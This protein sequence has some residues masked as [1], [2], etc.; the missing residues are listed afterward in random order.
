MADVSCRSCASTLGEV[1][2][3]LGEQPACDQFPA[4][5]D[6]GPDPRHPLRMWL[7]AKCGLA[8]LTE[9]PTNP[10]EPRGREPDALVAQARDAVARIAADGLLPAGATVA[11]YGS[12][13]GGSWLDLITERGAVVAPVGAPADVII[14]CFGLMHEPDQR[15]ALA[16]RAARLRPGG[17]LLIQF[18]SL[19]TILRAGQWNAL[20]HGHFA[21][22]ST[23]VLLDM[24]RS[25]GVTARTAHVF[26]LYGGTVLLAASKGG[27]GD[28]ALEALVAAELAEGVR[29]PERVSGMQDAAAVAATWLA[30]E[31]R[32]RR[33]QGQRVLGYSAASRA[34]SLLTLAGLDRTALP[35]I[36]DASPAK[37]GR[38]MP[39]TDIPIIGLDELVAGAP[40][41]VVLFVPDLLPEVRRELPQV[42]AGGG[43]WLLAEQGEGL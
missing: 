16:E 24:L 37:R 25:V 19:A 31:V 34:V 41:A 23:P 33:E 10:A 27:T 43:T 29:R 38:R 20:R 40:H 1:V 4:A 7:C 2:L 18:H 26:P 22:Y 11:E 32:R 12:P 21:Y 5:T 28:A 39:G 14:D 42:E 3:D 17:T 9:D 15:A 6:P 13:H 30:G 8:Q 36:A 35:A